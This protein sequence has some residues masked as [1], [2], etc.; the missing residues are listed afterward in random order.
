M[1]FA[2]WNLKELEMVIEQRG[3]LFLQK[4]VTALT[5]SD[6]GFWGW[7]EFLLPRPEADPRT[8][9]K[10]AQFLATRLHRRNRLFAWRK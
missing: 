3:L 9:H 1:P 5:G 7:R 8:T 4:L 6:D 10:P 2:E